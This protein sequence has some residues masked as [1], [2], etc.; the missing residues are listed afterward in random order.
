MY[1]CN[2]SDNTCEISLLVWTNTINFQG[3]TTMFCFGP[4][5]FTKTSSYYD[6]Q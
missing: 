6:A 4:E 1:F 3:T 2:N 5:S